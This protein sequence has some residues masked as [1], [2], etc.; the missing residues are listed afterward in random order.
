MNYSTFRYLKAFPL[1][2]LLE[3]KILVD[4]E[5]FK[6]KYYLHNNGYL[7]G[8]VEYRKLNQKSSHPLEK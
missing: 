4:K 6:V 5:V 7:P 1:F 3:R 2:L 8:N